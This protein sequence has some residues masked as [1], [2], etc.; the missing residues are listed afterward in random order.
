VSPKCIV[1]VRPF[2]LRFD[3]LDGTDW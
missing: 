2:A 1:T 3:F